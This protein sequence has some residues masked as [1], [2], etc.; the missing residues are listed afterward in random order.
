M[1]AVAESRRPRDFLGNRSLE[2]Y[3]VNSVTITLII[4]H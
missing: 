3:I 2:R 1:V 4:Q